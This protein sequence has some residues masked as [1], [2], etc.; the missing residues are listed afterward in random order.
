MASSHS[1]RATV[2]GLGWAGRQHL[3]AYLALPD[4]H[5]TA[6]SDPNPTL[7]AQVQDEYGVENAFSDYRELLEWGEA[8]LVSVATPNFAHAEPAIDALEHGM[9]VLVEKPLARTYAEGLSMVQAAERADR[10]LQVMFNQ[11]FRPDVQV[12]KRFIDDGGLG[13]V[14]HGKSRW[15]RRSGIPGRGRKWFVSKE[16]AG[17]GP[18]ID[19]GVHMLDMALYTMGEP[20]VEAVSGATYDRLGQRFVTDLYGADAAYEVE[21]FATALIRLDG[22]RTLELEASWATYRENGDFINLVLYGDRG[23][24]EMSTRNYRAEGAVRFYTDAGGAPAE[25][26]PDIPGGDATTPG[27]QQA[28]GIFVDRILSG[29]YDG[30]RGREGLLR[31]WIIDAIYRSAS[32]GREIR[33]EEL[34]DEV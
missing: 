14:Y 19:L 3:K 28:A 4:T 21:D 7:L 8:D 22:G 25:T 17:G 29:S 2:I 24:A 34:K 26:I 5:V 9:H 11:R 20:T 23:G 12:M 18:L 32:E 33:L 31:T 27:H 1:L 15:L 13:S 6:I 16:L 10:V 30:H